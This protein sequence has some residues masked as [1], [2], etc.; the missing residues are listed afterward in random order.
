MKKFI[1]VEGRKHP[2]T[3]YDL[4]SV[5]GQNPNGCIFTEQEALERLNMHGN[6]GNVQVFELVERKVVVSP[7]I[8]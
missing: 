8:V 3:M 5:K 1:I 2:V 7:R 6:I 4:L